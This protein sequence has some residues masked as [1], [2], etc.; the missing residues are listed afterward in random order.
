MFYIVQQDI[1]ILAFYLKLNIYIYI[2][3]LET[4]THQGEG[5]EFSHK[6]TWWVCRRGAIGAVRVGS[7]AIWGERVRERW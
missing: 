1:I 7:S 4:I 3:I 2:Y 5:N 6:D